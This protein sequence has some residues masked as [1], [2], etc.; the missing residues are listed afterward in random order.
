MPDNMVSVKDRG[1]ASLN[2]SVVRTA[3]HQT[4]LRVV[5]ILLS[6]MVTSPRRTRRKP[7]SSGRTSADPA[8][9]SGNRNVPATARMLP[10][11][12]NAAS[13]PARPAANLE[14]RVPARAVVPAR[15]RARSTV[16]PT[17]NPAKG[18]NHRPALVRPAV[19][20]GPQVQVGAKRRQNARHSAKQIPVLAKGYSHRQGFKHRVVS[21]VPVRVVVSP[22]P[23]A[24]PTA[25]T[26]PAKASAVSSP[27][28]SKPLKQ[29]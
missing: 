13:S 21:V 1:A 16:R 19:L 26:R 20:V 14:A 8:A 17:R 3:N 25:K 24:K 18:S 15:K 12:E 29:G 2:P 28:P 23:S 4:V 5:L 27:H 11:R 6:K 7:S 22:K 9:A 10:T